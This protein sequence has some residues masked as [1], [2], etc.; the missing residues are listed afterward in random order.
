MTT[1]RENTSSYT[2]LA[3]QAFFIALMAGFLVMAGNFMSQILSTQ[4]QAEVLCA[5]Q[6][7]AAIQPAP[8]SPT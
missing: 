1:S 3:E 8:C 5:A 6:K 2:Q 4:T 7:P